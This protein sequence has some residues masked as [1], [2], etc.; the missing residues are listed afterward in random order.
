[1]KIIEYLNSA[2][3]LSIYFVIQCSITFLNRNFSG[4]CGRLGKH[5]E[6]LTSPE[7]RNVIQNGLASH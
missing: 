7:V 5:L 3:R 4:L 1:M 2:N 6:C